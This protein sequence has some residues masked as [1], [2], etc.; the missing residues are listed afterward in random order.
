MNITTLVGRKF[1][2]SSSE[3]VCWRMFL[4]SGNVECELPPPTSEQPE[5]STPDPEHHRNDSTICKISPNSENVSTITLILIAAVS[6]LVAL[7]SGL[8]CY[9]HHLKKQVKRAQEGKQ[10][11]TNNPEN[12]T[13]HFNTRNAT[14][15][16]SD[17]T[18]RR[19]NSAHESENSIYGAVIR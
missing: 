8:I 18:A 1:A 2:V 16:V 12:Q 4:P 14:G 15:A 10:T 7:L 5:Y 19:P 13:I 6:V 9:L 3:R 17:A 11:I